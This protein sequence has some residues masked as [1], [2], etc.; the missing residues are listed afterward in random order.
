[1]SEQNPCSGRIR[2]EMG[3]SAELLVITLISAFKSLKKTTTGVGKMTMNPTG[4]PGTP[5]EYQWKR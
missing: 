2:G 3:S 1:M 5:V 4:G